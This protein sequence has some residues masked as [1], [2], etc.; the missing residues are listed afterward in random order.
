MNINGITQNIQNELQTDTIQGVTYFLSHWKSPH[1][2][3]MCS[4]FINS[5]SHMLKAA[6]VLFQMSTKC[7]II[8]VGGFE[9]SKPFCQSWGFL[10]LTIRLSIILID[11]WT[12]IDHVQCFVHTPLSSTPG[13][14]VCTLVSMVMHYDTTALDTTGEKLIQTVMI[15]SAIKYYYYFTLFYIGNILSFRALCFQFQRT[16]KLNSS[17]IAQWT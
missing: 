15:I 1:Y 11:K 17:I 9:W 4:V 3:P 14:F 12:A 5:H 6:L 16:H 2:K 7:F 8:W 10:L 13:L